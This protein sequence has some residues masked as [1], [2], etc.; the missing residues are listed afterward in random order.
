MIEALSQTFL[1]KSYWKQ[2]TNRE[3]KALIDK[4]YPL[5]HERGNNPL[6][7]GNDRSPNVVYHIER[8]PTYK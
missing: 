5:S 7:T 6:Y 8:L 2:Y 4:I 1:V 3:K